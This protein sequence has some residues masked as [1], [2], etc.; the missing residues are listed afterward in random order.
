MPDDPKTGDKP[1]TT[2]AGIP[3]GK[4]LGHLA[5]ECART[6]MYLGAFQ[7]AD[8]EVSPAPGMMTAR[9]LALH[10]TGCW[11]WLRKAAVDDDGDF[12]HFKVDL[13]VADGAEAARHYTAEYRRLRHGLTGLGEAGFARTV[14]AFGGEMSASDLCL[15]LLFHDCHHRGQLAAA[16]RVAGRTPPDIYKADGIPETE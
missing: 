8:L 10:L 4:F 3:L 5:A 1:D 15:D 6:R 11:Q 14:K 16:L 13:P 7:A 2:A 9:E 12:A